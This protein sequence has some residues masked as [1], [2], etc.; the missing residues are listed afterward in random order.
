MK[1]HNVLLLSAYPPGLHQ[2]GIEKALRQMGHSVFTAGSTSGILAE[3]EQALQRYDPGYHYDLVV[4]PDEPL[5]AILAK[6]PF[7]P[8]FILYLESG[9]PFLPQGLIEAPCPV[10]GLLTEDLLHADRYNAIS[11]YFDLALCTWKSSETSYR[12]YGHHNVRQWYYGARPEFC[13]DEGLERIYDVAFLGNL[14]RRVQRQRL[15]A[16]RKILR[17]RE[18]GLNVYVGNLL[19]FHDYNRVHCQ[20]KIVYHQGITDQVNM[21]VF[22]AM[23]AGCL[24]IMRRP[25]DPN[26]PSSHFFSDREDVIYCDTDE[27]AL[28]LIRYYARHE[29]ERRRIAE[30]GR[31]RVLAEHNYTDV[32]GQLLEEVLPCVPGEFEKARRL[33]LERFGKDERRRR[34]D[35]AWFYYSFGALEASQNQIRA[36][37]D[38][39]NDSEALHLFGLLFASADQPDSAIHCLQR[40]CDL[41]THAL[42]PRVN[43]ASVGVAYKRQEADRWCREALTALEIADPAAFPPDAFEGPYYPAVYD[44]FRIELSRA[45]FKHAAGP[46]RN[47][48]LA[49]LYRYRLH[50]MLGR[51]KLEQ[52]TLPVARLHIEQAL[53]VL[54]DDGDAIY[55]RALL[56]SHLGDPQ[57]TEGDLRRA[58]ELEP[59]FVEAQTDLALFLEQR[60][61]YEEAFVQYRDL[62]RHNPLVSPSVE[63]WQ[64]VGA[65]ALRLG[66]RA[67]ALNA[68]KEA[69]TLNPG[70][71]SLRDRIMELSDG[72]GSQPILVSESGSTSFPAAPC[73]GSTAAGDV[74]S[75]GMRHVA[76]P[77]PSYFDF[78]RPEVAALVPEDARRI[79]DVGCGGGALG[80]LLKKREGVEVVGIEGNRVAAAVAEGRLDRV[81]ALDLDAAEELPFASHSFDCI[82][83]ADVLEH[84]SD[85]ERVLSIL[86]RYLDK[87]GCLIV[88][89]PNV[90]NE[91]ILLDLLVHGRWQYQPAG[92]LDATHLR[93]FT[94][95]EIQELLKRLD[96]RVETLQASAS[97]PGPALDALAGAVEKL[98]GDRSRFVRE[99][100]VVQFIFRAR[101][102]LAERRIEITPPDR[103]R[104]IE[105]TKPPQSDS[106]FREKRIALIYDNTGRPDSPGDYCRK[107]LERFCHVEH[108]LPSRAA[109]IQEGFDLYLNI[110]DGREYL[111]PASLRPSAWWVIDTHL[112]YHWDL[113]KALSFDFVFCAQKDGAERLR[114]DGVQN[115]SWLPLA[116]DPEVHTKQ[117]VEKL[118]DVAFVGTLFHGPR[119]DL[120]GLIRQHFPNSF[121]GR[122]YFTEMAKIYN[123][124]KIVFNRSLKNDVN[125]RAFE[126]LACGSLLVTNDL[127]DNGQSELFQD[128]VHLA[129][130]RTP[131]EMLARIRYYLER[132]E[133]REQIASQ[134]REEVLARHTYAHRMRTILDTCLARKTGTATVGQGP[135]AKN[136][137]IIILACN[138]LE[139]TRRCVESVLQWTR[140]PY[141]L[142]LVDN[143]STDGT[144]EYFRSI[145]G[146]FVIANGANLGFAAGNNR[147]IQA[148]TGDYVVLLNNDTIVTPG[149]LEGMIA[150]AEE[151]P[152]IGIVG[153]MSNYVSGPQQVSDV[154]YQDLPALYEYAR[155]FHERYRGRRIPLDRIV[156]FCMLIKRAVISRI[157]SLDERF[158]IGNFED[159][160]YCL[161]AKHAGL[162]LV[163]AADVFIHHFGGRTF[164]GEGI[165]FEAAM[166]RG[167]EVFMDKW[168][169]KYDGNGHGPS[170]AESLETGRQQ[171]AEGK[172]QEAM[173][174]F[175]VALH[176]DPSNG[177]IWND[178]ACAH[179]TAGDLREAE[180]CLRKAEILSNGEDGAVASRNL[181]ALYFQ[182]Q[183]W[184]DAI[185]SYEVALAKAFDLDTLV[186]LS[187]CYLRMGAAESSILGFSKALELAPDHPEAQAG[188]AAA[189]RLAGVR[190][191]RAGSS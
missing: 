168:N 30:A 150:C 1:T 43:L 107:A 11:P 37:P 51:L 106:P 32:V 36:V 158:G 116:C 12:A 136:A 66:K 124:T 81:I 25:R 187:D 45:Y 108:F 132:E 40:A 29:E 179:V 186:A 170:S 56:H 39:R 173:A 130:Y 149:W 85:P 64:R 50:R 182:Q 28:D 143:G 92:I 152:A 104:A 114:R 97:A 190:G 178:L 57:R 144:L 19:F 3:L 87:D 154:S 26:D 112:Q 95:H 82:V 169:G 6:C 67:E 113:E 156:G 155:S 22:E 41:N 172:V 134:G 71:D 8:D 120:V 157:G 177:A 171:F 121:V 60:G 109:E 80:A 72:S 58:V 129:T 188:L 13:V 145:P 76:Q 100:Q 89:I 24:V 21:R 99:S 125:M 48:V 180:R 74:G 142:V 65:M 62:A 117:T 2:Y 33:R 115:V 79:L 184:M 103:E 105:T 77:P 175:K 159:D 127:S 122:A 20:S 46:E 38:F 110:D 17:L 176:G 63:L 23:G 69:S 161:R 52:G 86:L 90:R 146:A 174:A 7:Q 84:L 119:L 126:A 183:R 59:F 9:I 131:G 118:Y 147:G 189:E 31:R 61:R 55:D 162:R 123:Q 151:D 139:Y 102:G 98:G 14:N 78:P 68:F 135:A 101:P 70:D 93:F 10:L 96:L 44:R 153:P 94:L 140:Q 34:L 164:I 16:I 4:P 163:V 5:S 128:K 83:C 148:A 91:Q 27:E 165:D 42:L 75:R 141:E 35:Y 73:H 166:I 15:Y 49:S 181:G 47:A 88:S 191:V 18:E 138:Q 167:R 137:S 54:P 160:D 111:L 133:E 53:A 185:A